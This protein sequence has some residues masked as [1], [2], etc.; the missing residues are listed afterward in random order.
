[1]TYTTGSKAGEICTGHGW[2]ETPDAPDFYTDIEL[3]DK[4]H[5]K[6]VLDLEEC[7]KK[8]YI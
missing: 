5:T 3:K 1:L 6:F 2:K 8:G 4:Q 7:K